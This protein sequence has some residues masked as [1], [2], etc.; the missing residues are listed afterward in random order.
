MQTVWVLL[1][2][3]GQLPARMI[4]ATPPDL[5][6]LNSPVW[7]EV[8]LSVP[9]LPQ[10]VNPGETERIVALL[11]VQNQNLRTENRRLRAE[12]EWL[13]VQGDITTIPPVGDSFHLRDRLHE[14]EYAYFKVALEQAD[15]NAAKAARLLGIEPAAFR[16]R[17]V[18]LGLR[19]R[20]RED[21]KET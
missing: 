6:P 7:N 17:A 18:T 2:Q 16:A 11:E 3:S 20:S 21:S 15:G 13:R 8:D 4:Q 9:D 5:V 1:V 12:I 19:Q 14:I 10:I